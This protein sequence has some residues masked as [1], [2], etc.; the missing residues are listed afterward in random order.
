MQILPPDDRR[1]H[2]NLKFGPSGELLE[3]ML[4]SAPIDSPFSD[5]HWALSQSYLPAG[6]WLRVRTDTPPHTPQVTAVTSHS[7]SS[8]RRSL[9]YWMTTCNCALFC[10]LSFHHFSLIC[11]QRYLTPHLL[12]CTYWLA[13]R[14][15]ARQCLLSSDITGRCPLHCTVTPS[16]C[17]HLC[18][19]WVS[20]FGLPLEA[21]A[22]GDDR[23]RGYDERRRGLIASARVA[24]HVIPI[25]TGSTDHR[26]LLED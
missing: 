5:G 13:T 17:R 9:S 14:K 11:I 23:R 3:T 18:S 4:L 24:L 15:L 19:G 21:P 20:A 26:P 22:N 12:C 8:Q 6:D 2:E 7:S 16:D 25:D 10:P 1:G